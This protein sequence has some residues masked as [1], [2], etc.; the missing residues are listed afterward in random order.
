MFS[1]M[2]EYLCIMQS[3]DTIYSSYTFNSYYF[4]YFYRY[5]KT[6]DKCSLKYQLNQKESILYNYV[7]ILAY[8]KTD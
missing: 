5:K 7:Y 6:A 2:H 1:Q 3:K 4:L 8:K